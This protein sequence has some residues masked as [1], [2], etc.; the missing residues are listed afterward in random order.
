MST[1]NKTKSEKQ[2]VKSCKCRDQLLRESEQQLRET[3]E[4]LENILSAATEISIISTDKNGLIT[5]FNRGSEIMHGYSADEMIGKQTP[6]IFHDLKEVEQR[7]REL[8]LKFG[9]PISGFQVFV[10]Y[11][12]IVGRETREWTII[13]KDKTTLIATLTVTAVRNHENE[14]VG[15]LGIADDITHR[16]Q[17]E[18]NLQASE[19]RFRDLF[20]NAPMPYQSLDIN[21]NFLHVNQAWLDLVGCQSEQVI[22]HFFGDFMTESSKLLACRA[23][24]KFKSEGHVSSPIF[25]LVRFDTKEK[26][27]VTVEGKIARNSNGLFQRT[28]CILTDV[29]EQYVAEQELQSIT[30]ELQRSNS[31]LEQFAYAVSHDMRQPLRMVTSY[32]GLLEKALGKQLDEEPQQFLTFALQGAKRMDAMISSLLD[33]S[34]VGTKVKSHTLISTRKCVDE[35]LV[36]LTPALLE[37]SGSVEV[38]GEWIE[39]VAIQ[40]E[41]TRLLQNLIGNALKYHDEKKPPFVQVRASISNDFFRVEVQDNGIGINPNHLNRLFKVF[42]RLQARTR[43]EGTGVGLALCRKIIEHHGGRIGVES[44][45]EGLGCIFWFELPI[46]ASIETLVA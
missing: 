10:E 35:A 44:D 16:K 42:S 17:I 29:T 26:R 31:E 6:A 15:Y 14:I 1:L 19:N 46:T 28:H 33:Y 27:L 34:H 32:L 41:L 12:N 24:D 9:K 30:A 4:T 13:R 45:G 5:L 22:G 18:R 39:L 3:K 36:F 8:T 25:E 43:F 38:L 23:F 7:G 37:N 21:G 2:D 11:A 40:D 20:D